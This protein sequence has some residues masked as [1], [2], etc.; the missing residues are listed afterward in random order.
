MLPLARTSPCSAAAPPPPPLRPPDPLRE[1]EK[2]D[3]R[4]KKMLTSGARMSLRVERKYNEM[5]VFVYACSWARVV[6]ISIMWHIRG[7]SR[8]V[9]ANFKIRE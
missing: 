3:E 1:E 9:I 5:Y 8:I 7:E 6:F 4:R 2:G